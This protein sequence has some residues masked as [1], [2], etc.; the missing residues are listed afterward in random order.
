MKRFTRDT[1]AMLLKGLWMIGRAISEL[2]NR[3][4][5]LKKELAEAAEVHPASV[6]RYEGGSRTPS[7]RTLEKIAVALDVTVTDIRQL[8]DTLEEETPDKPGETQDP[9]RDPGRTVR[10]SSDVNRWRDELASADLDFNVRALLSVLPAF[11][12]S[13]EDLPIVV[14]TRDELVQTG[15]VPADVVDNYWDEVLASGF[16]E[17]VKDLQ[18]VLRLVFPEE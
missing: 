2:R 11:Q 16:V 10:T 17:T 4:G 3:K 1:L 9:S 13:V 8:A 15:N 6:S 5:W 18:H 12:D 7:G 14:V